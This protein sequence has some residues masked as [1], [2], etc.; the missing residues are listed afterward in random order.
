[1][2]FHA[3]VVKPNEVEVI[4]SIELSLHA[5]NQLIERLDEINKDGYLTPWLA[6]MVKDGLEAVVKKLRSQI[7]KELLPE[8]KS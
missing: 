2:T 3:R 1:M 7:T 4:L 6:S 8:G 5:A